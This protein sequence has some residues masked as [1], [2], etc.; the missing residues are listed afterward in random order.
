MTTSD[1]RGE[2]REQYHEEENGYG[3]VRDEPSTG[4]SFPV[5]SDLGS[6]CRRQ[7]HLPPHL[8]REV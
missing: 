6:A 3:T 4:W 5:E 7:I 2:R 8:A 1:A